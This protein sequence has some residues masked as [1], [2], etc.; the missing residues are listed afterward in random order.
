MFLP[1]VG[2]IHLRSDVDHTEDSVNS[3]F[4]SVLLFK[5]VIFNSH[6]DSFGFSGIRPEGLI[7][8]VSFVI[9]IG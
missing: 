3:S 8:F 9:S 7:L 4:K 2:L 5:Q 1:V 6:F